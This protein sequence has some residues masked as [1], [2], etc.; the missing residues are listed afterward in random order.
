MQIELRH[1]IDCD[2]EYKK[3]RLPL[4]AYSKIEEKSQKQQNNV[5]KRHE[6]IFH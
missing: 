1:S 3:M 2:H 6:T 5:C 4:K